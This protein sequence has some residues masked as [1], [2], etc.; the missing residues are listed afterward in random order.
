MY[1]YRNIEPVLLKRAKNSRC[2]LVTGARQ[3]DKSTLLKK[4]FPNVR[5][6]AFDDKIL[7]NMAIVCLYDS[8]LYLSDN[9]VVL[10]IEYI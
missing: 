6:I 2:I 8:K 1:I 9:L 7:L 3:V 5:F 4:L 10:P